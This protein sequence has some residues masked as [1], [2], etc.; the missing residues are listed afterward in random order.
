MH[1][2]DLRHAK[3]QSVKISARR[4]N[5]LMLYLGQASFNETVIRLAW[6]ASLKATDE[7]KLALEARVIESLKDIYPGDEF[8][9]P[10]TAAKS[11]F[12]RLAQIYADEQGR[13]TTSFIEAVQRAYLRFDQ[14]GHRRRP[15]FFRG[16]MFS[17]RWPI[18]DRDAVFLVEISPYIMGV[19]SGRYE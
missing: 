5:G 8:S 6:V 12:H 2:L 14:K 4:R 15:N 18:A 7:E 16:S 13:D 1:D 19:L 9:A 3:L 17:R 10:M 11:S